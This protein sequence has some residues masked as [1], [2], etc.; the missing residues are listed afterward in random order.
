MGG[1]G[2]LDASGGGAEL[3]AA[4]RTTAAAEK[5]IGVTREH[6]LRETICMIVTY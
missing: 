6:T 1:G 5:H 4:K 2:W 3:Q